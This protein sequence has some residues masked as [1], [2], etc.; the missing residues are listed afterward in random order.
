[1]TMK[2][3][4]MMMMVV[5]MSPMAITMMMTMTMTMPATVVRLRMR[6][7]LY[8]YLYVCIC[9][10]D[11][12]R[13]CISVCICS[14]IGNDTTCRHVLEFPPPPPF[15]FVYSTSPATV[16]PSV[17][18]LAYASVAPQ[19]RDK[20]PR[21]CLSHVRIHWTTTIMPSYFTWPMSSANRRWGIAS[22]SDTPVLTS[23]PA[24][25]RTRHIYRTRP[26]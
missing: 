21:V 13:I 23:N 25:R 4:V 22:S 5:M 6:L 10:C 8:M 16:Q 9:I 20:V 18:H 15:F 2:M 1:M 17:K 3:I 14:C 11:S 7:D 12:I 26:S 19:R 24:P